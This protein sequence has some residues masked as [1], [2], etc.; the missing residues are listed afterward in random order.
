MKNLS[1]IYNKYLSLI[2]G[3]TFDFDTFNQYTLVHHSNSI[4]GSTLTKAETFLLLEEQLTPKN[5]P[6][7]HTLMAID[8]LNA[9]KFVM[10]LANSKKPLTEEIIRKISS[11]LLKQTGSEISAIAGTFDSSK[12]D[13]RK[14]NVRAGIS[15]FINFEK[16]PKKVNELITYI[17]ERIT[18]ISDFKSVNELAFDVHFQ[19]VSIHPFADGNGRISRL[20][21]NYVQQ[22]HHIPLS[23]IYKEDK[24]EYFNALV[25]TRTTEDISIFRK[26]MFL[27]TEKYLLEKI[28]ELSKKQVTKKEN[29]MSLLF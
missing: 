16:V 24:Q 10:D 28:E 2:Q 9:L 13:F 18:K 15:T 7:E 26:F 6:L 3:D 21:M 11:L 14:V 5:K 17:N 22:Y 27:Q 1:N 20:L 19:L 23:V 29:G 4:E 8:H 12:G 25:E